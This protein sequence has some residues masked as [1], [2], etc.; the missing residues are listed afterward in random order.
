MPSYRLSVAARA[1]ILDILARTDL[2]FGS[3][4]RRRYELLIITALRDIAFDPMRPGTI[5]RPEI[6]TSV[7]TYHLRHSRS[8]MPTSEGVVRR[9]R[10]LL[11]FRAVEGAVIG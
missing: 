6:A 9:P 4:A 2:N 7:R 8:R 1:D 5:A 3:V 11:L 10:H